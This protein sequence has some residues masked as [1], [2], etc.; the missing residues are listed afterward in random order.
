M[1][2]E[3]IRKMKCITCQTNPINPM[4]GGLES[5]KNKSFC[6]RICHD[7]YLRPDLQWLSPDALKNIALTKLSEIKNVN[8][9]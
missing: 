7:L 9:K 3:R 1:N 5:N 6:S 2:G 4:I 8:Y